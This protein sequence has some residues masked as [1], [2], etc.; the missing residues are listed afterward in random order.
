LAAKLA[1]ETTDAATGTAVHYSYEANRYGFGGVENMYDPVPR[2]RN[3]PSRI[4][5]EQA[6]DIA[7]LLHQARLD[8]LQVAA[9]GHVTKRALLETAEINTHR[10]A[11][12]RICPESEELT[13]MIAVAAAVKMAEVITD[14]NTGW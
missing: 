6:R 10:R 8:E 14:M 2:Q 12:E 1:A 11:A 9:I 5:R 13:A 3:L 4:R 7:D